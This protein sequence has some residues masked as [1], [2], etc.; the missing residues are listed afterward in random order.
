VENATLIEGEMAMQG[1]VAAEEAREEESFVPFRHVWLYAKGRYPRKI[2]QAMMNDLKMLIGDATGMPFA[3]V[4]KTDVVEVLAHIVAPLILE[5]PNPTH[6]FEDF[7]KGMYEDQKHI[8]EG[9]DVTG[10]PYEVREFVVL[11]WRPLVEGMLRII[12]LAPTTVGSRMLYN[13]GPIDSKILKR[14]QG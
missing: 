10:V 4:S 9:W 5:D 8:R 3:A 12:R 1:S 11:G 7:I 2:N 13:L 6:A 14:L